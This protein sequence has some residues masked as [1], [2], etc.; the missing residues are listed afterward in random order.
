MTETAKPEMLEDTALDALN[1]AGATMFAMAPAPEKD[2]AA[3]RL[4]S[5]PD[6]TLKRG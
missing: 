1:G 6:L 5:Y 2:V 4:P 3:T